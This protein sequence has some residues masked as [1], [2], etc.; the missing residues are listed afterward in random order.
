VEINGDIPPA[1][2][3]SPARAVRMAETQP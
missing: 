3:D 1:A 2:F